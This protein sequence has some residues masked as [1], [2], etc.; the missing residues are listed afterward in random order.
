MYNELI[1]QN[2]IKRKDSYLSN[3][4]SISH[5]DDL[6]KDVLN[7]LYDFD[8]QNYKKN[9]ENEIL[10]NLKDWWINPDKGII[11]E[12]KL[13]AILFEY[14]YF[15]QKEVEAKAY[16]IGVWKNHQVQTDKFNMGSDYD[17][18]SGFY[19]CPGITLNFFDSLEAFDYS[20]LPDKYTSDNL[21]YSKLKAGEIIKASD[22]N[23]IEDQLGYKDLIELYKYMGML[24]ICEVLS[25]LN[26][27]KAFEP[28]NSINNF[29]FIINEHD[30]GEVYPLLIRSK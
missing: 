8:F 16:G 29:M 18:T 14:D 13:F 20:N 15:F 3:L 23:D 17:F 11:R 24:A 27:E 9:L 19:A 5:L 2:L 22:F 26:S 6:L 7:Q 4:N 28:L 25:K 12:E 10:V 21:D 30:T 1:R